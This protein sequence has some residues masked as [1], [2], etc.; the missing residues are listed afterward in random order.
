MEL[1]EKAIVKSDSRFAYGSLGWPPLY[2]PNAN[3]EFE[4]ELVGI[5]DTKLISEMTLAERM[6][7]LSAKNERGKF[8]FSIDNF[9]AAANSCVL[10][11][12][13]CMCADPRHS[14][15]SAR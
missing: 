5:E 8:W 9:D 2:P 10:L 3:V 7:Q 11:C 6:Q 13:P 1:G 14:G 12:L 15:T 4:I